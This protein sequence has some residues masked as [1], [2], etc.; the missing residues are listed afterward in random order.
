MFCFKKIKEEKMQKCSWP[1]S[2]TRFLPWGELK[3][4]FHIQKR[5]RFV[6]VRWWFAKREGFCCLERE[7]RKLL[8][9]IKLTRVDTVITVFLP[10]K[11]YFVMFFV[12]F[13]VCGFVVAQGN[14]LFFLKVFIIQTKKQT[15]QTN[16][17]QTSIGTSFIT[18]QRWVGDG[19]EYKNRAK[20]YHQIG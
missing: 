17:R 11:T 18:D 19:D 5:K 2:V 14:C 7:E 15:K 3:I 9:E 12:I 10:L 16:Y 13:S 20:Y 6:K 8:E 1:L 4:L